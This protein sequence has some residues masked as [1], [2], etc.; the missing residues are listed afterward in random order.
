MGSQRFVAGLVGQAEAEEI[1]VCG[2]GMV[3]LLNLFNLVGR[4]LYG[5]PIAIAA[6][7]ADSL[8]S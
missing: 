5:W 4:R 6:D 7:L 8:G 1:T 3:V 2:V